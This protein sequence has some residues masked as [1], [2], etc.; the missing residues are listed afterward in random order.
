MRAS[1]LLRIVSG[2]RENS[3]KHTV[4]NTIS[5]FHDNAMLHGLN[6]F[7]VEKKLPDRMEQLPST[8]SHQRVALLD[9]TFL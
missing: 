2:I 5:T 3:W 4:N 7:I 8:V 9:T 6:E 1:L